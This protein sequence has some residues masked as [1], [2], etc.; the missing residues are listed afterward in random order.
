MRTLLL[1]CGQK[2]GSQNLENPLHVL[3][4]HSMLGLPSSGE[5]LS[6]GHI[7]IGKILTVQVP[8][9]KVSTQNHNY[10]S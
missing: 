7:W 4:R 2:N 6:V 10:D 3:V 8:N 1:L 5:G 9:T